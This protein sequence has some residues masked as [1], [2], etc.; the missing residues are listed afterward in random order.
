MAINPVSL[1]QPMRPAEIEAITQ[2]NEVITAVNSLDVQGLAQ[3]LT[4]IETNITN[5]QTSV[6]TPSTGLLAR[7]TSAEGRITTNET[8]IS[9]IET[10]LY[11]DLDAV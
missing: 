9:A 2:L 3:R 4:T 10:T 8:D 1:S 6:D 7:M 11:T 5:L